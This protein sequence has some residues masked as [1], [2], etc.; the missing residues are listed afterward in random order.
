M[1]KLTATMLLIALGVAHAQLSFASETL[2]GRATVV[3]GDT[4]EIRGERIRLHGVDAPESWQRCEDGDG[5]AYRC[6]KEAAAALHRFLAVSR[7]TNCEF[8]EHDR[9]GRFVGVCFR[10][11]GREVNRWLVAS[12]NA[13]NWERYSKGEYAGAEDIARSRNSGIWRGKFELPC[14]ARAVRAKREPSC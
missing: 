7:P 5:V 1:K 3:D 2:M 12:G 8:V 14:Q 11:D 6:G 4:I 9:Y 13:V 10:A